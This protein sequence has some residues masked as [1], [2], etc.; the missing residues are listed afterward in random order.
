MSD[1]TTSKSLTD[2]IPTLKEIVKQMGGNKLHE[3]MLELFL[4]SVEVSIAKNK[5][6]ATPEDPFAN[7]RLSEQLG[8]CSI[9]QSILV[10]SC[11]KFK[12]ICNLLSKENAVKGETIFDSI[13]DLIVYMAFLNVYLEMNFTKSKELKAKINPLIKKYK[14]IDGF[15]V[16][17]HPDIDKFEILLMGDNIPVELENEINMLC[18]QLSVSCYVNHFASQR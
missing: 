1:V 6:Y 2:M 12:R 5:D 13:L 10:R 11:D 4:Q 3:R 9:P 7:F 8:L 18:K 17:Y 15:D 14:G 16:V